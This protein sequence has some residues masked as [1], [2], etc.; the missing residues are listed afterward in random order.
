MNAA[1]V[2]NKLLEAVDD[3]D[4]KAYMMGLKTKR[5][6]VLALVRKY[7]VRHQWEFGTEGYERLLITF[8]KEVDFTARLKRAGAPPFSVVG[9][10]GGSK[11]Y[12]LSYLW[13]RSD[14]D[15][16]TKHV[17]PRRTR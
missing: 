15:G 11:N 8:P 10:T 16:F 3:M 4:P 12:R 14:L 13:P 1:A 2:V 17:A 9:I 7:A 6:A 5:E